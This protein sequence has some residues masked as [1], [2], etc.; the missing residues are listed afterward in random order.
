MTK[1]EYISSLEG[2]TYILE[3]GTPV[4]VESESNANL[5]LTVYD[6]DLLELDGSG[7]SIGYSHRFAVYDE[8]GAGEAA[9]AYGPEYQPYYEVNRAVYSAVKA[10]VEG[11]SA[12]KGF[13]IINYSEDDQWAK[14]LVYRFVTDHI[15]EQNFFVYNDG[16]LTHYEIV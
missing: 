11:I 15:E 6:V 9:Y 16:G 14:V 5:N 13:I 3:I 7:S 8:G 4:E 1:A 12:V 10:Y 2:E